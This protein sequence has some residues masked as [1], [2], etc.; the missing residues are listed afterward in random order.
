[1]HA[2]DMV[3]FQA[4]EDDVAF[5][6]DDGGEDGWRLLPGALVSA[7]RHGGIILTMSTG[8]QAKNVSS[9]YYERC[10]AVF[11]FRADAGTS[12]SYDA[13]CCMLLY[14]RLYR[15]TPPATSPL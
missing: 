7:P 14:S 8:E 4:E 15:A 13:L 6:K 9:E 10:I 1:M 11:S 12:D 3:T 5:W 2:Y